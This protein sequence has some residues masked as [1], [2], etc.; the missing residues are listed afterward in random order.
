LRERHGCAIGEA[1]AYGGDSEPSC[2]LGERVF[3]VAKT[4]AVVS[5]VEIEFVGR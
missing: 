1:V 2:G 4:E 5:V 3:G